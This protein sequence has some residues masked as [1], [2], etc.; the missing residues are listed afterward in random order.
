MAWLKCIAE[1]CLKIDS[2]MDL[3]RVSLDSLDKKK[4]DIVVMDA[5]Y[6]TYD[7]LKNNKHINVRNKKLRAIY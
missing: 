6:S 4:Y 5:P 2:T 3:I 1:S 7:K